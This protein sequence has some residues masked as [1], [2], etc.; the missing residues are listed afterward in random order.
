[1][2]VST[3]NY[4]TSWEDSKSSISSCATKETLKTQTVNEVFSS[5]TLQS[6]L[7]LKG[8]KKR[9]I[10]SIELTIITKLRRVIELNNSTQFKKTLEN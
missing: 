3:D 4:F 1:M 8:T 2:T 5:I 6:V 7:V 9:T 10:D